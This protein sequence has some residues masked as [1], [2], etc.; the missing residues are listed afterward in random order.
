MIAAPFETPVRVPVVALAVIIV[1]IEVLP[2]VHVPPP[3]VLERVMVAAWHTDAGPLIAPG[4]GLTVTLVQTPQPVV[5]F[6]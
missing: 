6:T 1:A 3:V 4:N 2:L 5:E